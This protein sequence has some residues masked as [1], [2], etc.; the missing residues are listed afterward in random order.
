MVACM[1]RARALVVAVEIVLVGVLGAA[2]L[3]TAPASASEQSERTQAADLLA[4][5]P[6]SYRA[7]CEIFPPS[8]E[9]SAIGP[10]LAHVVAQVRCRP[11][12]D[13]AWA[14]YTRFDGPEPMRAAFRAY[15]GD[16]DAAGD[17]SCP[18][19][20][21]WT[22]DDEDA[23]G[24]TCY[25]ADNPGTPASATM[26]WTHDASNTLVTAYRSDDDLAALDEWWSSAEAG[27]LAERD[28]RGI[29]KALT[30]AQWRANSK[31][32]T[33]IVPVSLRRSC[34]PMALTAESLGATFS[35][36]RV[37]LQ[38]GVRCRAR[39]LDS[40]FYVRFSPGGSGTSPADATFAALASSVDE[41]TS[42]ERV[43]TLECEG[44][45]TWSR[46]KREVGQYACW[47]A[48][49]DQG[50]FTAMAWTDRTQ[51]VLAYATTSGADAQTLLRFWED[52]SGPLARKR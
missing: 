30:S 14:F 24:W 16:A 21:T 25:V 33:R 39:D 6:Q 36:Q 45:G 34:T 29:P 13:V 48:A 19:S 8:A 5:I 27:P 12:D 40:V 9:T 50:E 23:G 11:G 32:L 10:Q 43:G 22:Q 17:E 42:R 38:G 7:T 3:A 44:Q 51:D 41:S 37:W 20:G 1:T 26:V 15:N 35:A 18:G 46:A 28:T 31:A 52:D 2:L 4:S 49:D 47:Y